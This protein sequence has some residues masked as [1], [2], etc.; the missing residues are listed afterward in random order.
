[1]LAPV[2]FCS[3]LHNTTVPAHSYNL[4]NSLNWL[5]SMLSVSQSL[6]WLQHCLRLNW[7]LQVPLLLM[8]KV[9][10]AVL[11]YRQT[12]LCRKCTVN[13]LSSC[14]QHAISLLDKKC[15]TYAHLPE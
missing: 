5:S 1:M 8:V 13:C 15:T 14:T 3:L 2:A 4:S 12:L 9:V 6:V 11:R 7:R 10:S